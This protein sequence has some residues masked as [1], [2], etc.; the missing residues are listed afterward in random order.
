[1]NWYPKECCPGDIIRINLG[2]IYHYG[3]FVDE[4]NI[5]Q[6][7]L[8][9]IPENMMPQE[10]IV[11]C[12]SDID[13]FSCGKIVEVA[14]F[15]KKENKERFSNKEIIK[16][17]TECIGNGGYSLLHN[18]C[19][20]FVYYCAFGKHYCSVESEAVNRWKN[21]PIFDIYIMPIDQNIIKTDF[22]CAKRM[23]ELSEIS[24]SELLN[25]KRATWTLLEMAVKHS[26]NL[27]AQSIDFKK[28]RFGKWM[29]DEVCFSI[30]HSE[31]YAVVA[32]SN[33]NCG[34]DFEIVNEINSRFSKENI[35]KMKKR[36]K[37]ENDA[38]N[39]FLGLWTKKESL[40][41]LK[42]KGSFIPARV[43]ANFPLCKTVYVNEFDMIMSYC[44]DS[45]NK[46]RMFFVKDNQIKMLNTVVEEL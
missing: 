5:I 19:E 44:G 23:K 4:N 26:V 42:G 28:S 18:N 46:M 45:V 30:S 36:I 12:S 35:S 29:C 15:S 10:E 41:K 16:R 1:M 9:L 13:V 20:H 11:V 39:S 27:D 24:N 38:D 14:V 43:D 25:E 8:P 40:F 17:A 34:I 6:F 3:I 2:S 37:C 32:V 7:G 22:S 33:N 31:K 21:R